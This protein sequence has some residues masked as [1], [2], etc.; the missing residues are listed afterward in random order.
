MP[1]KGTLCYTGY[2][3]ISHGFNSYTF[4]P[5]LTATPSFTSGSYIASVIK[6]SRL[7]LVVITTLD[8]LMSDRFHVLYMDMK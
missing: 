1:C 3:V 2:Q 4:V 6:W 5:V 8:T 7:L